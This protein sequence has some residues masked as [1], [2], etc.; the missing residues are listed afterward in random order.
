M[1]LIFHITSRS[2]WQS[3]QQSGV[4]RA[5]SLTTE[6]FIHCSTLEQ[7]VRT[8]NAFFAGERGLV[9]LYIEPDKV[10]S[11]IRYEDVGDS[12]FPHIYGPL[13]LDAVN[14]VMDFEPGSDGK[15]ELPQSISH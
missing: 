2:Q 14:Q 8:A 11:E 7:V 3:A 10:K 9:L 15:F 4:Y 13:N 5:N 6:G 12:Q 1:R